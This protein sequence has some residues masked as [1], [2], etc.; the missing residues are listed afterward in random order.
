[1]IALLVAGGFSLFFTLLTTPL[2]I[3]LFKRLEWGQFIRDDGPQTHHTK[4]G[5]PTMGGIVIILASVAGYFFAKIITQDLPSASAMLLL[6]LFV[7]LGLVG[8]LDDFIK[9]YKQRNLGLRS[10][11]KMI[12][13][14]LIAVVFGILA[15]SPWLE[16]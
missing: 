14:T 6:F 13:Q 9:I 10:K 1:M 16:D 8:F 12:G 2:F 7:G 15:L 3:R 11:A 5:T 4:R